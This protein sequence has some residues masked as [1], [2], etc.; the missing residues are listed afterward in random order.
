MTFILYQPDYNVENKIED[1]ERDVAST[2]S[3]C[4]EFINNFTKNYNSD[5]LKLNEKVK[6][7]FLTNNQYNWFK[8]TAGAIQFSVCTDFKVRRTG[9][10][11][12]DKACLKKCIGY[13]GNFSMYY[14]SSQLRS[15]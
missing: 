7:K 3:T 11:V 6:Y 10:I 5:I 9:L 15:I 4:T 1:F 8:N 13:N 14:F 12:R 2:S